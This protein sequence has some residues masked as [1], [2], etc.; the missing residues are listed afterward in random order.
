[1]IK[2]GKDVRKQLIQLAE[3]K[4]LFLEGNIIKVINSEDDP[5]FATY[6]QAASEKDKTSRKLRLDVTKQ[7]QTQYREL[8]EKES[9]NE[10]LMSE[11][12]QTL[13]DMEQSSQQVE[14]QNAELLQWKADNE[15]MSSELQEALQSAEI[16]KQ[17][18]L[19]A[20]EAA[21]NDLDL[22]QKRTQTELIGTIVKV[23]LWIVV[24]VGLVTTILYAIT[25][26]MGVDTTLIGNAWSNMFGILL[27]NSFS[28]I[29]TIMG[30]KY[31]TEKQ[32]K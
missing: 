26:I 29:G 19:R 12:Q 17:E 6:L 15:R 18:A 7:I 25:L 2:F 16:A 24:G 1:M 27:T 9:Q 13:S 14:S 30:V 8:Q 22:I 20:K 10:Q 3:Q 5:E 11:L 23:A 32:N 21:E 31:A 4:K 28:I